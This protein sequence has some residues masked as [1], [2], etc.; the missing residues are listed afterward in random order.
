[1]TRSAN[2][3]NHLK[4]MNLLLSAD[5]LAR[6]LGP[7]G[8]DVAADILGYVSKR[9]LYPLLSEVIRSI[10]CPHFLGFGPH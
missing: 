7:K 4:I 9:G 6:N 3:V 10:V 5:V 2:A 8:R 1:M